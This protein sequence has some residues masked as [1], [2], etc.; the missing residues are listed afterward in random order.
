[1]NY[2]ELPVYNYLFLAETE[3]WI[4]GRRLM[5]PPGNM[6][7]LPHTASFTLYVLFLVL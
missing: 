4:S 2:D 6:E 5:R 7:Y 3:M 1:M